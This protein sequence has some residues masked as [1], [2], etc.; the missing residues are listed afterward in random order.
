MSE[1]EREVRKC[2]ILKILLRDEVRTETKR[3][4]H[5]ISV[6]TLNVKKKREF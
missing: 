2:C 3:N 1:R 5:F 6:K 4:D